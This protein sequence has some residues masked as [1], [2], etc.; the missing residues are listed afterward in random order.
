MG[1]IWKDTP[2]RG[3]STQ[4]GVGGCGGGRGSWAGGTQRKRTS[5]LL[6][7]VPQQNPCFLEMARPRPLSLGK[8]TGSQERQGLGW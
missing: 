1:K 8:T 5:T 7:G 6:A 2:G 3:D 4:E